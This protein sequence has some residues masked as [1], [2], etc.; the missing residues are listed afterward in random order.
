MQKTIILLLCLCCAHWC[1]AQPISFAKA[2]DQL[3]FGV[4]PVNNADSLISRLARIDELH[5]YVTR[6]AAHSAATVAGTPQKWTVKH[7][8]TFTESPM[9]PLE[10]DSGYIQVILGEG[11]AAQKPL[12]V[13]WTL[14]FAH[15]ARAEKSFDQLKTMFSHLAMKKQYLNSGAASIAYFT[16]AD[17]TENIHDIVIALLATRSDKQYKIILTADENYSTT[18]TGQ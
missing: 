15:K 16:A 9:P 1:H 17:H 4:N 7:F 11:S 12:S 18:L 5:H 6:P 3:H 10:V 14:C 2:V 8:F 13:T